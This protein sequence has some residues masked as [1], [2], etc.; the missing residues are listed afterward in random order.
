MLQK[1]NNQICSDTT[2]QVRESI[3]QFGRFIG[4]LDLAEVV[5]D[6]YDAALKKSS[7]KTYYLRFVQEIKKTLSTGPFHPLQSF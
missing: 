1:K 5:E 6:L 3:W 4:R 2:S 7:R